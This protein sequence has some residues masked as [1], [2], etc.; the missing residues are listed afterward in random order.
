MATDVK[1]NKLPFSKSVAKTP[2]EKRKLEIALYEDAMVSKKCRQFDDDD[3]Y[4]LINIDKSKENELE[5]GTNIKDD[6]YLR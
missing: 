3:C 1:L 6:R 2:A 5:I 4:S